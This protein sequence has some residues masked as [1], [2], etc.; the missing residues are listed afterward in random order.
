MGKKLDHRSSRSSWVGE[1]DEQAEA[2]HYQTAVVLQEESF[3]AEAAEALQM[4][5]D[6]AAAVAKWVA[7][8][9]AGER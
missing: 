5:V 6:R 4:A 2:R 8:V 7:A 3:Q 1:T 9:A